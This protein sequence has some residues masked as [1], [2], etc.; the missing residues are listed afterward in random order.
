MEKRSCFCCGG[1]DNSIICYRPDGLGVAQ[2]N[3]CSALYLP[4]VPDDGQL[5]QIYKSYS[6][7]K[8]YMQRETNECQIHGARHLIRTIWL[9]NPLCRLMLN[10]RKRRRAFVVSETCELLIRTGGLEGKTVLEIGPG[11]T[12]GILPEVKVWGGHGLAV[13]VDEG[14]I[15]SLVRLGIQIY[16]DISMIKEKVDVIYMS[17][18][19]EHVKDPLGMLK[20]LAH[21]TNRGGRIL[22]R[23]PNAGQARKLGNNWIGFCVDLEHLNY[24]D[25]ETLNAILWKAGYQTECV[26]LTSQP[27]LP[28]YLKMVDR[29]GFI[30]YAEMKLDQEIKTSNDPFFNT[31]EFMLTMLARL[32]LNQ[33]SSY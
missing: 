23:V 11:I 17:M 12:G 2:C 4:V 24:F 18:V 5:E 1:T 33:I 7:N 15:E 26:W 31:G 21:I 20:N 13:E 28:E 6:G 30:A 27:I 9:K 29:N 16:S 19:L 32:S 25:Q 3:S 10:C 14:A 22:I 8:P